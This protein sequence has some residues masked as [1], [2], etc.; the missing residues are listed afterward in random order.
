M[1]AKTEKGTVP[2][3]YLLFRAGAYECE[4]PPVPTTAW[5]STSWIRWINSTG[6]FQVPTKDQLFEVCE[7][8][9]EE[10][11][12]CDRPLPRK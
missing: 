3:E 2:L 12:R 7:I 1:P 8:M 10:G 9:Q 4:V 5:D 6:S 11:L